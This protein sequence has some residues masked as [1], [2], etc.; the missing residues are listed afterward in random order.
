MVFRSVGHL[1]WV[2]QKSLYRVV[3]R[4]HGQTQN[5]FL[6]TAK[7]STQMDVFLAHFKA[8]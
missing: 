3:E 7:P 1:I 5:M 8:H 6:T 2:R 4:D